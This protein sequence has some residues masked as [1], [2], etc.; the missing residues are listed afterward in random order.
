[1]PTVIQSTAPVGPDEPEPCL[2]NVV[3]DTA[4]RLDD[5][6]GPF[7]AI[8]S[9]DKEHLIRITV[10]QTPSLGGWHRLDGI[11]DDLGFRQRDFIEITNPL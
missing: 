4:K 9:A 10:F 2:G 6:V 1:V 8:E 7:E 3:Q 11:G 5:Q